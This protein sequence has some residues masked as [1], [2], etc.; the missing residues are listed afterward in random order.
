VGGKVEG[1]GTWEG[2]I[3]EVLEGEDEGDSKGD[4]GI[5]SRREGAS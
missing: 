5:W 4:L 3:G 2:D 1:M